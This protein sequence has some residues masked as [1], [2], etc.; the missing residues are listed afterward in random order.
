MLFDQLKTNK[1]GV[2]SE[3][4]SSLYLNSSLVCLSNILFHNCRVCDINFIPL[5]LLHSCTSPLFLKIGINV[6]NLHSS[7]IVSVLEIE[8]SSSTKTFIS[9]E[10]RAYHASASILSGPTA[11]L[12]FI[13]LSASITLCLVIFSLFFVCSWHRSIFLFIRVIHQFFKMIFPSFL[14]VIFLRQRFSNLIL[15]VLCLVHVLTFIALLKY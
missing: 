11:L 8:L 15:H 10:R 9:L 3:N 6:L 14:Y 4:C 5:W 13:F 12:F 2:C 7:K 1:D